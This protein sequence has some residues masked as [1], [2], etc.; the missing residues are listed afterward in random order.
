M[1]LPLLSVG[2]AGVVGTSTHFTASA[3]REIIEHHLAGRVDEAILANRHALPAFRGVFATQ[4]CMMV[5][6]T[7]AARGFGVG[8][9]RAPMGVVDE[10]VV[11][12]YA[13]LLENLGF[14]E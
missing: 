11:R 13:Q 14:T 2:G 5:K 1:L 12:D 6:A 10:D 8:P 9:C 4:G 3:A 7:L